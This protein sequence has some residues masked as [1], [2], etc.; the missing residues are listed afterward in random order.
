[1]FWG[2]G[3]RVHSGGVWAPLLRRVCSGPAKGARVCAVCQQPF[4]EIN[5]VHKWTFM[6]IA[7]SDFTTFTFLTEMCRSWVKN[8]YS[9]HRLLQLDPG[10]VNSYVTWR[11]NASCHGVGYC[12]RGNVKIT[13]WCRNKASLNASSLY[14]PDR[15]LKTVIR[16]CCLPYA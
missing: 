1:M 4:T 15:L 10:V 16:A 2:E 7:L 6:Y 11:V 5:I 14:S 13:H 8:V 12:G 9:L 3:P